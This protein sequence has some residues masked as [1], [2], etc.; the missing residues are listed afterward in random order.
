[1]RSGPWPGLSQERPM[2]QNP[3]SWPPN[4]SKKE[5][6]EHRPANT[7]LSAEDGETQMQ[8]DRYLHLADNF[9]STDEVDSAETDLQ[10]ESDLKTQSDLQTE[11]DS[12]ANTEAA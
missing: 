8:V 2:R 7:G 12:K 3:I 1:M 5:E 9:L 10:A 4:F 6:P 11:P